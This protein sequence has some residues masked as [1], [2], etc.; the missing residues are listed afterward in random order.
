M[1]SAIHVTSARQHADEP[2]FSI[3]H[4]GHRSDR[5]RSPD[6]AGEGKIGA[7]I[8]IPPPAS[9]M[10]PAAFTLDDTPLLGHG[11]AFE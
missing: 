11:K 8:E 1:S 2:L 10:K 5:R 4:S 9:P 6:M 7:E 3:G